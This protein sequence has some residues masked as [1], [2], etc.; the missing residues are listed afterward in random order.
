[1]I[2]YTSIHLKK[3]SGKYARPLNV[4]DAV[5][6]RKPH[7]TNYWAIIERDVSEHYQTFLRWSV[8]QEGT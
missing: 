3:Q 7:C 2:E 5:H 4:S 6:S 1:M 8:R